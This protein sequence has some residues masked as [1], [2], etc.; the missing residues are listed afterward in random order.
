MTAHNASDIIRLDLCTGLAWN[1]CSSRVVH[2][3][4]FSR[5]WARCK[6]LLNA[7]ISTEWDNVEAQEQLGSWSPPLREVSSHGAFRGL[8]AD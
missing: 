6:I 3:L 5:T 4:T 1:Q 8:P 2:K 7:G